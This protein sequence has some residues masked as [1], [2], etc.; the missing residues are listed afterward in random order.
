MKISEINMLT[1]F[2]ITLRD[3]DK[4]EQILVFFEH[5]SKRVFFVD[6]INQEKKLFIEEELT[7]H[8]SDPFEGVDFSI[9]A[10]IY[11]NINQAKSGNKSFFG[12]TEDLENLNSNQEQESK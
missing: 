5:T 11:E 8:C 3:E 12:L 4:F 1:P 6:N 7:K 10:H 9:P 2:Q